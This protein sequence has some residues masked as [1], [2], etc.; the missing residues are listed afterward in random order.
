MGSTTRSLWR[1]AVVYAAVCA[2]LFQ[3]A[4]SISACHGAFPPP[5]ATPAQGLQVSPG[6]HGATCLN[7]RTASVVANATGAPVRQDKA[8]AGERRQD[9]PIC[10]SQI[11]YV[12]AILAEQSLA[13]SAPA[14]GVIFPPAPDRTQR[15]AAPARVHNR[16]PPFFLQV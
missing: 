2:L 8:P 5:V 11:C 9:C 3:A 15:G 16:D 14:R 1:G 4:L 10:I 13:G 12:T 7:D 6:D